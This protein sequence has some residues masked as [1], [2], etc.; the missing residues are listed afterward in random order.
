MCIFVNHKF[1]ARSC[2]YPGVHP[3]QE[4]GKNPQKIWRYH[5]VWNK[6][7]LRAEQDKQQ[8]SEFAELTEFTG[9]EQ[10]KQQQ[11]WQQPE[12]LQEQHEQQ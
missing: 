7:Q 5:Y 2:A 10:H 8:L 6:Q 11:F 12:E 9:F 1:V 3:K 4:K